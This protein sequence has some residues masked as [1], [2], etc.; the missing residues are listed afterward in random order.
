[1]IKSYRGL[2][3]TK[4]NAGFLIAVGCIV[5]T[6]YS[7]LILLDC[8]VIDN[9]L[10]NL[11]LTSWIVTTVVCA[12]ISTLSSVLLFTL[13]PFQSN[14]STTPFQRYHSE[15][16]RIYATFVFTGSLI[17]TLFIMVPVWVYY[18]QMIP[19]G[20]TSLSRI[21]EYLML[22]PLWVLPQLTLA[23]LYCLGF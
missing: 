14:S 8:L 1:M 16:V 22:Y 13:Y 4:E 11:T 6:L 18:T 12:F 10:L 5:S 7:L 23:L 9:P 17:F 19:D 15:M 21:R 2:Y 3:Q 20:D